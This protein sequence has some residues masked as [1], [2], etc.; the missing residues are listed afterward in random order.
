MQRTSAFSQLARVVWARRATCFSVRLS[1][2]SRTSQSNSSSVYLPRPTQRADRLDAF[3][4]R[5]GDNELEKL[6]RAL[7]LEVDEPNLVQMSD[8][9]W[10][11][12]GGCARVH[13]M[14]R[15]YSIYDH[16]FNNKE[17]FPSKKF[18]V[19][20]KSDDNLI[21]V[22]RGN[23]VELSKTSNPPLID[24]DHDDGLYS[25]IMASP[26]GNVLQGT[27]SCVHWFLCNS[28]TNSEASIVSYNPPSPAEGNG[29]YRYVFILCKQAGQITS[30]E[31][32]A[33]SLGS[34]SDIMTKYSLKPVGLSFFQS[35]YTL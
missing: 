34:M 3:H 25:V 1:S 26:D 16:L 19:Q 35:T 15:Y 18:S 2:S 22:H 20:Y 8:E 24:F 21:S 29:F 12:Y 32:S 9:D 11:E 28:K 10:Q 13:N 4:Q 14:A 27:D 7:Q 33:K 17:F 30:D 5:K 23:V 31:L 6:S